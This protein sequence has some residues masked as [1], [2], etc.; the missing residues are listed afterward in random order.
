MSCHDDDNAKGDV[1]LETMLA[2]RPLV[3][4]SKK[5]LR[6][7]Q[8]V[9]EASMPPK[10]AKRHPP[11]ASRQAALASLDELIVKFDYGSV[12]NPGY[13]PTRRLTRTEYRHTVRALLGVDYDVEERFPPDLTG[14]SGFD[15]SANSLFLQ[16]TH[17]ERYLAAADSIIETA[18]RQGHK[19]TERPSAKEL[20]GTLSGFVSRAY[21]R[22]ATQ[23]E[24]NAYLSKLKSIQEAGAPPDQAWRQTLKTVLIA[25]DFL[26]RTEA[27]QSTDSYR[28]TDYEL[29]S[30][31]SYFLWA[32]MPDDQLLTLAA[33]GKLHDAAVLR[34]QIVRMIGDPR[35][36]VGLGNV[37]AGQWLGFDKC[38]TRVRID[39]I[40][41]AFATEEWYRSMREESAL[42]F[43]HLV[44]NNRPIAELLSARTAESRQHPLHNL[45]SWTYKSREAWHLDTYRTPR[46]APTPAPSGCGRTRRR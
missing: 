36:K 8:V 9:E 1:N 23:D 12:E 19:A 16:P 15:N 5:W 31:I 22:P 29:A 37:F 33:A 27:V 3:R 14:S 42:F 35:A 7:S 21:R 24:R 38:G 28:I 17:L 32:S 30:R 26:L 18:H 13:E 20:E 40:D 44:R 39:P 41:N 25:P 45:I 6:V 10:K 43:Y 34:Q 4:N 46:H 2:Q 11:P